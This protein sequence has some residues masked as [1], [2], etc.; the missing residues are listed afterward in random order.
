MIEVTHQISAVRRQLGTRVLEAGVARV[1]TISQSYATTPDDLWHACTDAERIRRW[2]LPVSG[3]LSVGG[4]FHLEGNASG[5]IERCDR[6]KSFAATWEFGGEISWIEVTLTGE[7]DGSTR[8]QLEHVAH[9]DDERW[10]EFGPGAVGIG[11][12]G[13]FMGL[14]NHI[15]QGGVAVEPQEAAA[16]MASEDGKLFMT[17]SSDRWREASV[18]AGTD[19][20]AAKAAADRC[21]AAYTGADP[22]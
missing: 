20:E 4:R 1:M 3:D 7:A 14:A 19:P 12:D 13:A 11:W 9:V 5:T 2:F 8:L 17:L 21:T 18:A 22:G 16:W 10:A 6:P 15:A